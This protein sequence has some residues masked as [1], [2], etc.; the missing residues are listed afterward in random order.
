M[1]RPQF[2]LWFFL[3]T[4]LSPSLE[5]HGAWE[6]QVSIVRG[7]DE[8]QVTVSLST[9]FALKLLPEA[10][11]SD[12]IDNA[13]FELIAETLKQGA[14]KVCELRDASGRL[15]RPLAVDVRLIDDHEVRFLLLYEAT[16]AEFRLPL[17]AD[18]PREAFCD[19]ALVHQ[20]AP[21][22]RV[23]LRPGRPFVTLPSLPAPKA[24][25]EK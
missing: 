23:T 4:C 17:L 16:P 8:A 14:A 2:F 13:R 10:Q 21:P 5:A 3:T 1:P 6:S 11:R 18:A 22:H 24:S 12:P 25:T 9:F 19:I 20:D 15:L 7:E